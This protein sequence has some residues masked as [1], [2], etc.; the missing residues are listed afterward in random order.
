M[1]KVNMTAIRRQ[2]Y[3]LFKEGLIQAEVARRLHRSEEAIRK[4]KVKLLKAGYIQEIGD[5]GV[6]EPGPDAK[7]FEKAV[8]IDKRVDEP[9]VDER[10][11]EGHLNPPQ[12]GC[13]TGRRGLALTSAPLPSVRV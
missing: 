6:F 7:W 5:T 9:E 1:P 3:E 13:A 4:H 8:R 12:A 10:M 11:A 2:V